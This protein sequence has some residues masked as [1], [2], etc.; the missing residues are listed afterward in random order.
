MPKPKPIQ[1][2]ARGTSAAP[3]VGVRWGLS[4]EQFD[5]WWYYAVLGE[6]AAEFVHVYNGTMSAAR[7]V[8][9]LDYLTNMEHRRLSS[10]VITRAYCIACQLPTTEATSKTIFEAEALYNDEAVQYLLE[11]V[12]FRNSR[13]AVSRL[14]GKAVQKIEEILERTAPIDQDHPDEDIAE[15]TL[16]GTF[17]PDLED[18]RKHEELALGM[19]VQLAKIDSRDRADEAS[20]RD[21]RVVAEAIARGTAREEQKHTL[22]TVAEAI[23]SLRMLRDAYSDEEW[24]A[25]ME[26]LQPKKLAAE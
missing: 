21:K 17:I 1:S 11:R 22:P 4:K 15:R 2:D 12:R 5:D 25:V 24:T 19:I 10:D 20:R 14:Y 16:K 13:Y 6:D 18:R 23:Q 7:F 8:C 3:N 9:A 26:S